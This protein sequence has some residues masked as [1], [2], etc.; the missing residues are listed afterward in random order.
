MH[1]IHPVFH[2]SMIEPATLNPFPGRNSVSDPLVI[3]DGEP[4]YKISSILD[5]KIDKRRKCKLQY[6]VQWT[7][8]EGMDE[9]TSW[10]PASELS[11]TSELISD[12]HAAYPDKP[13]PW[14]AS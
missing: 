4:E 12:F 14:P 7:G 2:V 3:I 11:H 5:S 10:L 8:Y 6:L 1:L 13:R 9:D